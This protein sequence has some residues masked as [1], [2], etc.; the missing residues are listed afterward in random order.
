MAKRRRVDQ[1]RERARFLAHR[2]E[3]TLIGIARA[4]G[5]PVADR[6]IAKRLLRALR[7]GDLSVLLDLMD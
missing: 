2:K 5:V 7:N 3:L 6:I 4:R 1:L